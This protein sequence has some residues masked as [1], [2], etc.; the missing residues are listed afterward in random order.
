MLMILDE[1]GV[2]LAAIGVGAS[3]IGVALGFG[4]QTLVRDFLA[5]HRSCSSRTSTASV[6]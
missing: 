1:L 4:A 3:I 2:N 5:G 6:T